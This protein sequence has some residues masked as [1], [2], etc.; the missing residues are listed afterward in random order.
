[1]INLNTSFME[2]FEELSK[3]NEATNFYASKAF[4]DAARENRLDDISF[5]S[6]FD[7]ELSE[8]GLMDIFNAEGI[9]PNSGIWSR[10]K[11]AKA[12]N[13]ESWAIKAL[14]KM[15]ALQFKDKV[16]PESQLRRERSEAAI[17]EREAKLAAKA[18]QD[19]I[20]QEAK[21]AAAKEKWDILNERFPAIQ[22]LIN[23]VVEEFA[24]EKK[25]I[26]KPDLEKAVAL[27]K[28]T[29]AVT[30]GLV[31]IYNR[32]EEANLA[33]LSK[34]ENLIEVS[35][36]FRELDR[37]FP[38]PR[39]FVEISQFFGATHFDAKRQTSFTVATIEDDAVK[40]GILSLLSD[41]WEEVYQRQN[42]LAKVQKEYDA[43]MAK[44]NTAKA[45]QAAV[46]NNK[47]VD[48]K[49]IST[50]LM[51]FDTGRQ[52]AQRAYDDWSDVHDGSNGAAYSM[53]A[54]ET[55]VAV[56]T[57]LVH[58]NWQA[59]ID[60]REVA[61]WRMTDSINDLMEALT[62]TFRAFNSSLTIKIIK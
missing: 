26:L 38:N 21:Y 58:C 7:E 32:S 16:K 15:W 8:L 4:W 52:E 43:V 51:E 22:E 11:D 23:E 30:R 1:M 33:R 41:I 62:A 45:A 48:P 9:L 19:R 60:D 56:G 54:Y 24:T 59:L 46:D 2:T 55:Q 20:E 53:R 10:I 3:L 6:A 29:K 61:T 36:T 28:E 14:Q 37:R 17:A 34:D 50:I 57:Y 27:K 44:A 40:S 25:A 31:S 39:I 5:H 35:Y 13:P 42:T 18:E 47:P 49:F 12:A